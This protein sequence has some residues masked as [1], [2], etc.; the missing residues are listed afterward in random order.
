M[1]IKKL[2]KR[3]HDMFI[4]IQKWFV[5]HPPAQAWSKYKLWVRQHSMGRIFDRFARL[6]IISMIGTFFANFAL[7]DNVIPVLQLSI[8]TAIIATFDKAK[9]EW[10]AYV[11]D[12]K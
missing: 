5:K 8:G 11:R 7:G 3:M 4:A 6:F 12:R 1:N 2:S 9:N 10:N